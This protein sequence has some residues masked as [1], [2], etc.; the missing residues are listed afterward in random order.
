M[1]RAFIL[2]VALALAWLIL[3]AVMFAAERVRISGTRNT[4]VDLVS[5]GDGWYSVRTTDGGMITG[6][7]MKFNPTTREARVGTTAPAG[8]RIGGR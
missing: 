2:A 7:L 6:E 4:T 3:G 8:W 5:T 1:K